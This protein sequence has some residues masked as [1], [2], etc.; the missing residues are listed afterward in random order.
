ML[1]LYEYGLKYAT[2]YYKISILTCFLNKV[3]RST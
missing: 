3:W 2:F 1:G